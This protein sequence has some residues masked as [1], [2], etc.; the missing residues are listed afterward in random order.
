MKPA[1]GSSVTVRI[2]ATEPANVTVPLAG[3]RTWSP[4]EE[5]KSTPQ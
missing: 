4:T 2:P 3:D 5:A 1:T